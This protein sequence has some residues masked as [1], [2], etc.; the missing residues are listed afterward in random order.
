M[1]YNVAL[2]LLIH[3]QQAVNLLVMCPFTNESLAARGKSFR[4]SEAKLYTVRDRLLSTTQQMQTMEKY[5][6][7]LI[8][9]N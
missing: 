4:Q 8:N 9:N 1:Q 6:T 5:F 7:V 3:I 2:N